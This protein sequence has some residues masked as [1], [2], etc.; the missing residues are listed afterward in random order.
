MRNRLKMTWRAGAATIALAAAALLVGPSTASAQM[1]TEVIDA[2][3]SGAI[4]VSGGYGESGLV[5]VHEDHGG[6]SFNSAGRE[7][8][9]MGPTCTYE[10]VGSGG[11][12]YNEVSDESCGVGGG[13]AGPVHVS[14]GVPIYP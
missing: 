14:G 13:F 9:L 12:G 1:H 7:S 8:G 3:G 2:P 11:P 5:T 10:V 4:Q 6:P